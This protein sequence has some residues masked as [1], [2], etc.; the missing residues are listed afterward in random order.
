M[1]FL[2]RKFREFFD[3]LKRQASDPDCTSKG[4]PPRLHTMGRAADPHFD[5][6]EFLYLRHEACGGD[7]YIG[8][9]PIPRK[10]EDQ[11]V[12]RGKYSDSP[13][14]VLYDTENGNHYT[15]WQIAKLQVGPVEKIEFRYREPLDPLKEP[16]RNELYTLK[17]LHDPTRCMYPHSVMQLMKNNA[18]FDQKEAMN[19]AKT[20]IRRDVCKIAN[21]YRREMLRLRV[22][23][24]FGAKPA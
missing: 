2:L 17:V 15:Q 22:P 24:G 10:V 11:S 20:V 13:L 5:A 18:K 14:D 12:N 4:I 16:K 19:S 1:N 23:D 8:Q 9:I 6:A 21:L 7:E 3:S